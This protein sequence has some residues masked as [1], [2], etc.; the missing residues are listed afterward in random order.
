[1]ASSEKAVCLQAG[2]SNLQVRSFSINVRLQ[3]TGATFAVTG[4]SR[5]SKVAELKEKLELVAG[6]PTHLQRLSYLDEG[7][8]LDKSTFKYNGIIPGA[9]I[10]LSSWSQDG[11]SDLVKA[12]SEGNLTKLKCLGVTS[13]SSYNTPNSLRLSLDQKK[14]WVAARASI[15][16]FIASHRGHLGMV[17][18]LLQNGAN[19]HTKTPLGTSPLHV[20]AAMGNCDCIDELLA[21]GAETHDMDGKGRTALDLASLF[22][23]KKVERRL[24]LYQWRKRAATVTV[25]THLDPSELFAHQKFDS[26]LKTWI[27]GTQAKHYMANLVQHGDF[28]GSNINAP[29]KPGNVKRLVQ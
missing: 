15:A 25:K 4:C 2:S 24:F 20:A 14:E 9:T 19:V 8:L 1:M 29:R 13:D 18:Y 27:R 28:Y 3:E 5:Q 11:C 12:A 10:C 23:Q 26:K 7:D 22:G 21:Y 17:R 16:L 6:I